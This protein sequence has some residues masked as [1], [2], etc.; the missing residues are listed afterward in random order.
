MICKYREFGDSIGRGTSFSLL[1][2]VNTTIQ[3]LGTGT[4]PSYPLLGHAFDFGEFIATASRRPFGTAIVDEV[5]ER[6]H[7]E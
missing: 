5:D 4:E 7:P 6:L 1:K 2:L 3:R